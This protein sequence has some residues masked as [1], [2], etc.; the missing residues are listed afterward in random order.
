MKKKIISTALSML[1]IIFIGLSVPFYVY[2]D[3][4]I[5]I[6]W[7]TKDGLQMIMD[8]SDVASRLVN[9]LKDMTTT[10]TYTAPE[11]RFISGSRALEYIQHGTSLRAWSVRVYCYY[12]SNDSVFNGLTFTDPS[13]NRDLQVNCIYIDYVDNSQNS[14]NIRHYCIKPNYLTFSLTWR[15]YCDL[16]YTG[17]VYNL[18][19]GLDYPLDN[20]SHNFRLLS[21]F[22][23]NNYNQRVSAATNDIQGVYYNNYNNLTLYPAFDSILYNTYLFR[24]G[25]NAQYYTSVYPDFFIDNFCTNYQTDNSNIHNKDT[26]LYNY[27]YNTEFKQGDVYNFADTDYKVQRLVNDLN[28][29]FKD[30]LPPIVTTNINVGAWESPDYPAITGTAVLNPSI[31]DFTTADI[32]SNLMDIGASFLDESLKVVDVIPN[33]M[34]CIGIIFMIWICYHIF[35]K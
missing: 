17:G 24:Y 2:A 5:N 29:K 25:D 9:K 1:S 35:G 31:V 23:I 6:E 32:P 4:T 28:Y 7:D 12:V 13:T 15:G 20:Y 18:N 10:D 3:N 19:D 26:G 14:Q 27:Y 11:M 16:G 21:D 30:I 34:L 22:D 8:T 33:Y